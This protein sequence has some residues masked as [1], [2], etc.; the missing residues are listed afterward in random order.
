MHFGWPQIVFV[1][2][3]VMAD[4]VAL[5]MDGKPKEGAYSFK[6]SAAQSIL[7]LL[8]VWEGGFFS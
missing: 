3:L 4:G 5:A 7:M 1:G 8:L 2:F 6:H